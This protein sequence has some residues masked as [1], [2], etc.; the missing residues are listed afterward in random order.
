MVGV[1]IEHAN[2]ITNVYMNLRA[3][4]R[5]M[6]RNSNNT[7][8]GWDTDAYLFGFT[9]AKGAPSSL[10]SIERAFV[11]CGSYLRNDKNVLLDSLSKVYS[12]FSYKNDEMNVVLQGQPLL[13][14]SIYSPDQSLPIRLNGEVVKP[15]WNSIGPC[16]RLSQN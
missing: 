10:E 6:H 2:K 11:I 5:R 1:Q 8:D 3:D 4:G 9:R 7:V 12:V 16:F 14:C 13:N 15:L